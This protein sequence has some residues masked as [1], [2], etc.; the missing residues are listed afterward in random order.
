MCWQLFLWYILTCQAPGFDNTWQMYPK[1]TTATKGQRRY[2][3]L[4]IVESFRDSAGRSHRRVVLNLRT[5][6]PA[7]KESL[8]RL[9][10]GI[11]RLLGEEAIGPRDLEAT[12]A[13]MYGQYWLGTSYGSS[14]PDFDSLGAGGLV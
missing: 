9:G 2:E 6:T 8:R 4:Q 13:R 5:V 12:A 10:C 3:Y 11:I 14:Y 1:L 7:T